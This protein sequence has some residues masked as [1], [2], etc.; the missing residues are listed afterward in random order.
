[1]YMT[2]RPRTSFERGAIAAR[3]GI[4]AIFMSPDLT[5]DLVL[6]GSCLNVL[7]LDDVGILVMENALV[8]DRNATIPTTTI[9]ISFM[10]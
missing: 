2:G 10:L 7:I 8:D 6:T 5:G 1:M 4:I 9:I 3:A